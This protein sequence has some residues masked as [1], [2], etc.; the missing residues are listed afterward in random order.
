[1]YSDRAQEPGKADTHTKA[2][3]IQTAAPVPSDAKAS[4]PVDTL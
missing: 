2:L 4:G 1:M 3:S